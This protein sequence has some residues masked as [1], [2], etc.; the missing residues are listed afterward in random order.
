M[1]QYLSRRP[2]SLQRSAAA[3]LFG[4]ALRCNCDAIRIGANEAAD[5]V[6]TLRRL[7]RHVSTH[8]LSAGIQTYD[9][10]AGLQ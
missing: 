5:M 4:Q 7:L 1:R 9:C 10:H 6:Q 8:S 3:L 2:L